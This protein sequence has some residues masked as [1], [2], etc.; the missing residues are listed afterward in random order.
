LLIAVNPEPDSRLPYLVRL[1]LGAALVFR[2]SGTWLRTMAIYCH[3]VSVDDS[4]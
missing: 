3:P 1:P 2:T 4:A